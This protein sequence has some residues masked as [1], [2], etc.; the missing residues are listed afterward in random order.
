MMIRLKEFCINKFGAARKGV[1]HV[2]F[3]NSSRDYYKY[4]GYM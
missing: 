4:E 1:A 3:W 2:R